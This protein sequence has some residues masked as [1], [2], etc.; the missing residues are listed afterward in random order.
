MTTSFLNCENKASRHFAKFKSTIFR[1]L[2]V[3]SIGSTGLAVIIPPQANACS[4]F[5]T[6][7][8]CVTETKRRKAWIK[9][10]K[11]NFAC[12]GAIA[13]AGGSAGSL[14]AAAAAQC[15][16]AAQGMAK[17]HM[18]RIESQN[19][20]KNLRTKRSATSTSRM[21]E[22]YYRQQNALIEQERRE[23]AK[24]R[25]F[26]REQA[27]AER[28]LMREE[29]RAR[30]RQED[31]IRKEER[32]ARKNMEREQRRRDRQIQQAQYLQMGAGL[33]NNLLGGSRPPVRTMDIRPEDRRLTPAS[34]S[35][36]R[37]RY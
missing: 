1:S 36:D 29:F 34:E 23:R 2:V 9:E 32:Q 12:A 37:L 7:I 31:E 21:T 26:N 6:G 20:P 18:N 3:A 13:A 25:E 11:D 16:K 8:R 30:M 35:L 14:S 15:A 33:L 17:E 24:E 4:I 19:R 27:E 28:Q 5:T 22:D 10:N